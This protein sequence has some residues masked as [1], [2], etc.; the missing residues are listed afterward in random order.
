MGTDQYPRNRAKI[1]ETIVH[2]RI[3]AAL[4]GLCSPPVAVIFTKYD[5]DDLVNGKPHA[6]YGQHEPRDLSKFK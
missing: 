3:C 6:N 4:Y 5:N 2:W 1:H